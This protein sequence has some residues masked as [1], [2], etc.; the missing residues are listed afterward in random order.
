[1]IKKLLIIFIF[2]I[3]FTNLADFCISQPITFQKIY[4]TIGREEYGISVVQASDNGYILGT[5]GY[6]CMRFTPYGDTLWSERVIQGGNILNLTG[7][8]FVF[9]SFYPIVKFDINGNIL[10]KINRFNNSAFTSSIAETKDKGYILS[11]I[12]QGGTTCYP[13]I[14]KTDSS[15]NLIWQKTYNNYFYWT[16]SKVIQVDSSSYIFTG[17]D[18]GAYIVKTDSIGNILFYKNYRDLLAASYCLLRLNN[19]FLLGGDCGIVKIDNDGNVIWNKSFCNIP[20]RPSKV[21][22][23]IK[24]IDGGFAIV[25]ESDTTSAS[26]YQPLILLLKTD[27]SGNQQ[28]KKLFGNNLDFNSGLD[29]KQTSDSGYILTGIT[30]SNSSIKKNIMSFGDLILIKTDFEGNCNIVN[31]NNNSVDLPDDFTLFQ[32][33]PNPFNPATTIRYNISKRFF[34]KIVVYDVLGKEVEVLINEIQIPGKYQ[35]DFKSDNLPSGIYFLQLELKD[36]TNA[37]MSFCETKKMLLIK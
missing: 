33:Y 27:S 17:Y 11:G 29:L 28:W 21:N 23:I 34:T 15:G 3:L 2:T 37:S 4:G 6:D 10:L 18:S 5:V 8:N 7:N 22:S 36:E 14:L 12:E 35:V 32:N 1:M 16:A 9:T 20:G 25:G 19:G 13:Y 24:T 30:F 31:I 26:D